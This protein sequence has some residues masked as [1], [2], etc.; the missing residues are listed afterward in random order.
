M[1]TAEKMGILKDI[2]AAVSDNETNIIYANVKS[3][4]GKV[5]VVELGLELDN[6]Y[7]YRRVIQAL[8]AIPEV[9]S[10]KRIQSSTQSLAGQ[11][12]N[13]NKQKPKK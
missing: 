6:I 11:K 8:Q 7:T 12:R 4:P 2:I 9:Y 3:K 10:V 5:G 13:N 1:E